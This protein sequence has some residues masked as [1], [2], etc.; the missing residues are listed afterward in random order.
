MVF[1]NSSVREDVTD[2]V[3]N[4]GLRFAWR[5]RAKRLRLAVDGPATVTAGMITETANVDIMN[6]IMFCATSI[7]AQSCYGTDC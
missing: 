5:R 3:L 6:Q 1:L 7:W 4:P 2:L